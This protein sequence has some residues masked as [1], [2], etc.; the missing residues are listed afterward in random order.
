M[1]SPELCDAY[2]L[3]SNPSSCYNGGMEK[4]RQKLRWYQ[5]T[6]RSLFILMLLATLPLRYPF[7]PNPHYGGI[8][9]WGGMSYV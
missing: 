8:A 3:F 4:P 5:F 6:L 7:T 2:V 1:M 9:H